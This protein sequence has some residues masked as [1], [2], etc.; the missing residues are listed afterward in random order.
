MRK[1]LTLLSA[2]F[3]SGV[4]LPAVPSGPPDGLGWFPRHRGR[5][6]TVWVV[7]RD[8]GTLAVFDAAS[9]KLVKPPLSVGGGAHDIAI[10]HR[11]GKAYTSNEADDTISVIST[12]SVEK[13]GDIATGDMPH[14]MEIGR[15]GR[16]LY[17]ALVGTNK[18][19]LI[20]T[21][22]DTETVQ[23]V[24]S[25]SATARPHAP[26]PSLG[27][28]FIFVAHEIGN[29]LTALDSD[30][31]ILASV[32]PGLGPS[33]VLPTRT[34]RYLWVSLRNDGRVKRF[35]LWGL[36]T[37]AEVVIGTGTLPESLMLTPDRRTLVVSMRAALARLAFVD[38][39]TMMLVK[40]LEIGGATLEQHGV[41]IP[42]A[43]TFGDLAVMSPDGKR[44]YA[45]FDSGASGWGGVSV[46]DVHRQ[47]KV[48]TWVYPDTGRPHG[49]A[50]STT[51][52][53]LDEQ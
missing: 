40:I 16:T 7:N 5:A 32:E 31:N 13:L 47:K 24:S 28:R 52:L 9:G 33:E 23:F 6:D 35:D 34:G 51:R 17:V 29:L 43:S 11:A 4:A 38:T 30:G 8:K 53:D 10:S 27:G 42:A 1:L 44:V 37:P 26:Y 14:H 19:A 25:H 45:T 15:G 20:D 49:I 50:Y 3:A 41:E 48:D 21:A 22:T 36:E 18:I 2:V 46:V 12:S 39:R